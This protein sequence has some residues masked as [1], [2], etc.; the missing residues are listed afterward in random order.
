MAAGNFRDVAQVLGEGQVAEHQDRLHHVMVDDVALLAGQGA[1]GDAQVVELA[2]IVFVARHIEFETPGIVLGNQFGFGAFEQML[3]LVRQQRLADRQSRC[4]RACLALVFFPGNTQPV[5][6]GARPGAL[7]DA[8]QALQ[9]GFG[10][11]FA[12]QVAAGDEG[13]IVIERRQGGVAQVRQR[14]LV[15]ALGQWLANSRSRH[16]A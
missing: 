14:L 5:I 9:V 2:A 7:G 15:A 1:A 16:R 8:A 12:A 11:G 4:R 3:G 10:H 6:Q 13:E